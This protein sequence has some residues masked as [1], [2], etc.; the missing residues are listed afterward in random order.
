MKTISLGHNAAAAIVAAGLLT[1]AQVSGQPASQEK[2]AQQIIPLI[3]MDNVPLLDAVRNLARQIELNF[4]LDP[5]LLANPTGPDGSCV[6]EPSVSVRWENVT[7]REALERVLKAHKLK[8]VDNPATTVARIVR[9]DQ[10]VE[11]VTT[12]QVGADTN[13]PNAVI[14]LIVMD[15]VPLPEALKNLSRQM[16]FA[17]VL[18]P[19]LSAPLHQKTLSQ[20]VSIRWARVTAR[21][22]L[23]ALLDN[24]GL[25]K[26]EDPTTRSARIGLKAESP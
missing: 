13:T 25:L 16:G 26:T 6:P 22:A 12:A 8:L 24:Y 3:V 10:A 5:N 14:P 2:N 18:D 11:P 7:A 23:A 15:D 21:Q 1:V 20:E 19:S 9:V 4:L 17:L